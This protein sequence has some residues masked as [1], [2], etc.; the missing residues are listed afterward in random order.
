MCYTCLRRNTFD[1]PIVNTTQSK[2]NRAAEIKELIKQ[3][4]IYTVCES[5]QITL[6][7][8]KEEQYALAKE[9]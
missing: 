1:I 8:L 7:Q 2:K 6:N 4:E 9:I 5:G 3:L